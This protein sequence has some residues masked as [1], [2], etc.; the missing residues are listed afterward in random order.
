M[1]FSGI[2]TGIIAAALAVQAPAP[3]PAASTAQRPVFRTGVNYVEVDANVVDSAGKFVDG[4]TKDDF[5]V[6]EDGKPQTVSVFSVVDI[7]VEPRSSRVGNVR[8][9]APADAASNAPFN[10]RIFALVLDEQ[11]TGFPATH[12]VTSAAEEF[13][14]KYVGANDLV[15]VVST[16]GTV[17]QGL[18]SDLR[19]VMTT[20]DRFMGLQATS[21]AAA[22]EA[23]AQINGDLP[24]FAQTDINRRS[25]G[26]EKDLNVTFTLGLIRDL[27]EYLGRIPDRRKALVIF[28]GGIQGGDDSEQH[29]YFQQAVDA[30]NRSNVAIYGVDVRGLPEAGTPLQLE[31]FGDNPDAPG[32]ASS[33]RDEFQSGQHGAISLSN[34]TGGFAVINKN[35]LAP[36]FDRIVQTASRYYVLGY[37]P[38]K[39]AHDGKF[40]PISVKVAR[41]GMIIRTRAGYVAPDEKKHPAEEAVGHASP[42]LA[43][44]LASPL[45]VSDVRLHVSAAPFRGHGSKSSIALTVE[46]NADGFSF[47]N[48]AD[49]F[50]D[51]VELAVL[52][53]R[54]SHKVQ[55]DADEAIDL[56]LR[57]NYG[58]VRAHGIRIGHHV[59]LAPGHYRLM[60]GVREQNA[61]IIGTV[62]LDVDVPD[63]SKGAVA[64]SG[65][66]LTSAMSAQ[67]PTTHADPTLKDVLPAPPTARR[68]FARDDV[69]TAFA[70]VYD[71]TRDASGPPAMS[72]QILG[73]DGSIAYDSTKYPGA[74]LTKKDA[75]TYR[76]SVRIPLAPLGAGQYRLR[77][78][79]TSNGSKPASRETSF[80]ID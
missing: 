62:P 22:S 20:L 77:F 21:A 39:D 63:F 11:Q 42:Q 54:S 65:I 59:E 32:A 37:Y 72:A 2:G 12:R 60:V 4:L 66:L 78:T 28:G 56:S 67:V 41:P 80:S 31:T 68:D 48:A 6:F 16:G 33:L 40:H 15:A 55:V 74:A 29:G 5:T 76:Y 58:D 1:R 26:K 52:S 36:E 27:S 51:R 34:Q 10:G 8:S 14:T 13:V 75:R 44:A 70:E 25:V 73:P 35:T 71:N 64:L 17:A 69:L 24:S 61:G 45:P 18:T 53:G 46:A 43:A 7:P 38:S 19:R 47:K 49:A 79:A 3:T 9:V 50:I 30:A 57:G 23:D